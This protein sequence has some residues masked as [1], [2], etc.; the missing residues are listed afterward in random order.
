MEEK[1]QEKEKS[2]T[3]LTGVQKDNP[4]ICSEGNSTIQEESVKKRLSEMF[5]K[6]LT[7]K[8]KVYDEEIRRIHSTGS[9]LG[10]IMT[11]SDEGLGEQKKKFEKIKHYIG[12]DVQFF[13]KQTQTDNVFQTHFN[14]FNVTPI[15]KENGFCNAENFGDSTALSS[16]NTQ[17]LIIN[18]NYVSYEARLPNLTQP[19]LVCKRELESSQDGVNLNKKLKVQQNTSSVVVIDSDEEETEVTKAQSVSFSN[20]N[21]HIKPNISSSFRP[22]LKNQHPAPLPFSSNINFL[23]PKLNLFGKQEH[24]DFERT[25]D[26]SK[27]Q[28]VI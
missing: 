6:L 19:D 22:M 12:E 2:E 27:C 8:I 15:K 4:A 1:A 16:S 5:N 28:Q 23:L 11:S 18:N 26:H 14:G 7:S 9:D 25:Q 17:N 21:S 3:N 20:L 13:D 10:E 24:A